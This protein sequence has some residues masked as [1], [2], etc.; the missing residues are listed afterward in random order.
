MNVLKRS[1]VCRSQ[2]DTGARFTIR[3]H[4]DDVPE[5]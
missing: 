3:H 2:P 5:V 1:A 4:D